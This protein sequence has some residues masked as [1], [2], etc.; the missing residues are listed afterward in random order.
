MFARVV[1]PIPST[2]T[3][4]YAIPPESAQ[5]A[6]LGKRVVVPFG[7]K[8]LTGWIVELPADASA[9]KNIKEIINMPDNAPL[10]SEEDLAF[11]EWIASYYLHPLG[12]VLAEALPSGINTISQNRIR[13][14]ADAVNGGKNLSRIQ[15]TLLEL[16][17]ATP[18][19]MSLPSLCR[20]AGEKVLHREILAL[21]G[22]G[23]I[24]SAEV[25]GRPGILAKQE[26]WLGIAHP[27]PANLKMTEKQATLLTL[28]KE[29]AEM[30]VSALEVR[31]RSSSFLG[32]LAA[33]GVIRLYKK[34]VFREYLHAEELPEDKGKI[35]LNND[36]SAALAE[37]SKGL[38]SRQFSPYL[39]HGVTGSG[40][41]E[42]YLRAME[43]VLQSKGS[44][45]YLVPEIA[46]TAQL[47]RRVQGH[48]PDEKIA[49]LH[50]GI[51]NNTRYDQWRK[52]KSGEI[53]LIVG[54]RSAIFAP[55]G[56]LRLIVVDEEHDPSYKQD[57]RLHYNG[58]DLA[59]YRGKKA[60]AVVLLGSAT[61]G[62]Q[63]YFYAQAGIYRYLSLPGR[64]N[65]RPLPRVE[66]VDMR[67]E[68]DSGG[69]MPIF[70][71][72]LILALGETL[73]AKKQALIFLNR[74]GFHTYVFCQA[75]GHVFKCPACDL[76]LTYHASQDV[77]KCHHCDFTS[78]KQRTCPAC[79]SERIHS[80]GAG[81][82]RVEE[83]IKRLF[84]AA[85]IARI[86]SDTASRKGAS[87]KTLAAFAKGEIDILVG[88]QI[89]TKGHDFPG[90]TLVGVIAADSSL[91]VPDFRAAER[92]FQILSQVAGRGGRGDQPGIVVVQT[93][94]PYHHSIMRAQKH[95]YPGFYNNELPTRRELNYPPYSRL[96]GLHFSSLNE[97]KGKKT[98]ARIGTAARKL[99]QSFAAGK[100][101]IIGPAESP[102]HRLRGRYRWQM[103]VRGKEGGI[104]RQL[105]Q[106]LLD[107]VKGEGI[108]I[109]ID[110]DPVHFM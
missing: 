51:P 71:R 48:F 70:S 89:I 92:T 41:T 68:R 87:E 90:I 94:T 29:K 91:N 65:S 54:A 105:A 58:R 49:V 102:L 13:L 108:E 82:E 33:R 84:P 59:L 38:N 76:A 110:V 10:F 75:C 7:A 97:D 20:K 103:L 5:F 18:N 86:D 56:D 12:M 8:R 28:L 52:I 17:A 61:P 99:A 9:I 2:K 55:A 11:F 24:T 60:G 46:L 40:K 66:I 44:A 47:I 77:L 30:P 93:F 95:D 109:R 19:G 26:K 81:T 37:I 25:A 64:V 4:I 88:T 42:I 16:L 85:A 23:L 36:Q 57:D 106:K 74:R 45:L 53:R 35:I 98:V 14:A 27:P 100:A 62:I 15:E 73:S 104:L 101:D 50:S 21:E 69:R 79:G 32:A 67:N 63:T 83:E 3:F 107:E 39:L 34:E 96:I 43:E 80:Q 6:A 1:I 78:K 31:L 72:R 22:M